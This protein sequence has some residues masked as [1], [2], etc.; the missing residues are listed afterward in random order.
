MT[1]NREILEKTKDLPPKERAAA[2]AHWVY[3][4]TAQRYE[5]WDARVPYD[6]NDLSPE[7]REFNIAS[8]ETWVHSE[9]VAQA[10]FNAL[11]EVQEIESRR[12]DQ[13]V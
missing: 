5:N 7:A 12:D 4:A 1:N 6:W 8:I 10:W 9:G 3:V 2:I 11:K 13:S